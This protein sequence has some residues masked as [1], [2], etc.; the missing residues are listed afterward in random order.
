MPNQLFKRFK[1]HPISVRD[2]EDFLGV[3]ESKVPKN[4]PYA[5][6]MFVMTADGIGSLAEKSYPNRSIGLGGTGV[7]LRQFLN[8][9]AEV[10]GAT[11]DADLLQY[12]RAI[13]DA[14]LIG[15]NV[16]RAE[17]SLNLMPWDKRFM[18]YRTGLGKGKPINIIVTGHGFD[19]DEMKKYPILRSKE[20][21]TLIATS[22]MGYK[23][24]M[25][26]MRSL[27]DRDKITAAFKTFG[28]KKVD[29]KK[30]FKTLRE[31]PY[32]VKFIDVEGGP[33]I[34]GQ[35]IREKLIDE[36]RITVSPGIA[37]YMN[38]EEKNRPGSVKENFMPDQIQ[39]MSLEKIGNSVSHVFLRYRI[40]HRSK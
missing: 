22:E 31:K 13:A 18:D 1:K 2:L 7:A 32:S 33:D 37:G 3:E 11:V 34:A 39:I 40:I 20:V 30:L 25:K 14:V 27:K 24:I 28:K 8:K 15:S 16:L 4:R 23:H 17:P 21:R 5:W 6:Y 38:S 10:K 26:E 35:L 29:F 12:G 9:R 36:Y 19:A